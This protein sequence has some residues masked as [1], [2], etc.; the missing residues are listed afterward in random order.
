MLL[1]F[2]YD[3]PFFIFIPIEQ[4]MVDTSGFCDFQAMVD[5]TSATRMAILVAGNGA[6]CDVMNVYLEAEDGLEPWDTLN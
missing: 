4:V 3:T 2:D 5:A 6:H 1:Y